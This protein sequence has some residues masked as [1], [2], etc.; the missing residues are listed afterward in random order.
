MTLTGVIRPRACKTCRRRKVRCSGDLPCCTNCQISNSNCVYEQAR[1]DRLRE[2][3]QLNQTFVSLLRDLSERVGEDDQKK[4]HDA[5]EEAEDDLLTHIPLVTEHSLGKRPRDESSRNEEETA[6]SGHY[7]GE[8]YVTASVGSNEDLDNLNEDLLRTRE[9]RETGYIGQNSE[10]QWLRSVQRQAESGNTDPVRQRFGPPGA[11]QGA[12]NQRSDALHERRQNA[13]QGSMRYITDATFYLDSDDIEVDIA[14]DPYEVPDPETA[15]H[16]FNCYMRT[17]HSSFPLLPTNFE[18]QFRRYLDSL[19]LNRPF[20]IPEKW[21]A[22]M[23]LLFAIAAKYSHL[24]GAGWRGDT[25][26]HLVY[27]TRAVHLLGLKNTI[28]MISGPDLSLVQA[29]GLLSFYFLVIGHVSRA[30]IVIGTSMRLALALGL[31]LRNEDRSANGMRKELMQNT[32][33]SLHAI[34][35][36]VSSITGRPPV[37]AIEDCTVSLPQSASTERDTNSSSTRRASRIRTDYISPQSPTSSGSS[38]SGSRAGPQ[39]SYFVIH[40]N[41]TLISQKVLVSLYS[42]RTAASSW[43]SVQTKI[44]G[45]LAELEEWKKESLPQILGP[46][47]PQQLDDERERFLLRI[48]YWSTKIL[49]TRPCLC[50]L[51]RRIE[52]E[53]NR[54]VDFNSQAAEACVEA[55]RELTKLLPDQ[56]DAD[57]IYSSGPWWTVI[58]IIMQSMAVLLLEMAYEGKNLTNDKPDLVASIKKLLSCL[59]VMQVKDPVAARALQVVWRILKTCAP[60]LHSQ[61]NELLA[62]EIGSPLQ[63]QPSQDFHKSRKQTQQAPWQAPDFSNSPIGNPAALDPR[64]FQPQTTDPLSDEQS[65]VYQSFAP[66]P[67]QL[68]QVFGHPFV[69]SF[70]QGAPIVDMQKLWADPTSEGQFN[71]DFFDM[72]MYQRQQHTQ[73]TQDDPSMKYSLYNQE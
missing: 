6:E 51:E 7:G 12:A 57:F 34:E 18:D 10:I 49:I 47:H 69:T 52:N 55:A 41:M 29:T 63:G 31:H 38:A 53:S 54:S 26:D 58:H 5:I 1:R 61:A 15:E 3:T 20:Q 68:P 9:S 43:Q 59:R 62:D 28:M 33:W 50:R 21:R 46:G 65:G 70:D 8:A 25:R 24:T 14:V 60:S 30:W 72:N 35:C 27:M 40:V 23:N 32:W 13:T 73:Q 22:I 36:L 37:I 4:I 67:V 16:L 66:D 39:A 42:P 45:L 11:S 56:P 64:L 48:S 17:V 19:R 71:M 2:A 44:T